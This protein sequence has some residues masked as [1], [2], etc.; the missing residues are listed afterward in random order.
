MLVAFD[1]N[2]RFIVDFVWFYCLFVASI[3]DVESVLMRY[4]IES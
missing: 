2:R 3:D 1:A 4:A